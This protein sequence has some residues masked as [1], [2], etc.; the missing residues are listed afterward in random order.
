MIAL[1]LELRRRGHTVVFCTMEFYREKM[2]KLGFEFH[3]LRP[4][5]DPDDRELIAKLLDLR[6]GPE[7]M[8]K[9]TLFPALR[10]TYDDLMKAVEGADL[11]ITGEV[12][13]AARSVAEKSGVKWASMSLSPIS[14]LS[15]YDP[16]IYPTA[17]LLEYVRFLP[18]PFHKALFSFMRWTISDWFEPY[19]DFRRSLG[20]DED[21]D[22]IFYGKA[23]D[24]LHLVMFSKV[25]SAPQPDWYP[26][27]VQTGFCFY[28]GQ[29][30]MG[31]IDPKLA[32]FLDAGEPPIVFTLG[33]AAVMDAGNF[34]E[35]SI[36]A[37]KILNKRAVML[38]G[39]YNTPP[40]GLDENIVGFEY[41]PY[42]QIFPK[43]A[44]VVHQGGIG[45]TSQVLRAG[46]PMLVMPYA[47]DQPD[48]AARCRRLGVGRVVGRN[49]YTA[50]T[51]AN[52]LRPLLSD[53]SYRAR[54]QEVKSVIDS[55]NG[56]L[57]A[58][59]AIEAALQ[60]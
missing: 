44:C 25:L 17:E 18:Q 59:D 6:K 28:D 35:E 5:F 47:H 29:D 60:K 45:T 57:A 51:A 16:N 50:E 48:N 52:E 36:K 39:M 20:L 27:S 13:Y 46:V 56:T 4:S 49:Y 23:S 19:K 42:S 8:I 32:E 40:P 55:E 38:Y 22:P 43:A 41:A 24:L 11:F 53:S 58:C 31:K 9:H 30:D 3:P 34:Y 37:A 12:I 26:A 15:S 10:D 54:A 1:A 14:L 21:H 2:G 7:N 33:S